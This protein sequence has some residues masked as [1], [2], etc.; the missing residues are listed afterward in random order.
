MQSK[1]KSEFAFPPTTFLPLDNESLTP[2]EFYIRGPGGSKFIVFF[3]EINGE[4]WFN[5]ERMRFKKISKLLD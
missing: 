2:M 4:L 5:Y 1:E 3:E